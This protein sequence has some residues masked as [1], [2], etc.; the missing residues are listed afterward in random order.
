[1]MHEVRAHSG[2]VYLLRP[3]EPVLRMAVHADMSRAFAAPWER[4]GPSAPLPLADAVRERRPVWVGGEQWPAD[5]MVRR[6]AAARQRVD[7]VAVLL[8]HARADG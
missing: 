5:E 6:S 4:G 7:D 8:L 1:M 3:D 2:A